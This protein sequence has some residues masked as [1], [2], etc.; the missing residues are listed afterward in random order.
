MDFPVPCKNDSALEWLV[1][2]VPA[3]RTELRSTVG[4]GQD[5]ACERMRDEL[6][7]KQQPDGVIACMKQVMREEWWGYNQ[8]ISEAEDMKWARFLLRAEVDPRQSGVKTL[9]ALA[10]VREEISRPRKCRRLSSSKSHSSGEVDLDGPADP[11][12]P[13]DARSPH[14]AH[15]FKGDA[16]SLQVLPSDRADLHGLAESEI[17][18][19][20][21]NAHPVHDFEGDAA[22][23][24][25][26]RNRLATQLKV[27]PNPPQTWGQQITQG[28]CLL[29]EHATRPAIE[30]RDV[31]I[32]AYV[33]PGKAARAMIDAGTPLRGP[34]IT[35]DEQTFKWESDR[36][37]MEQ[38]FD[39]LVNL[40][41]SVSVQD[42][43]R[44]YPS[45]SSYRDMKLR[46]VKTDFLEGARGDN[47]L[48]ILDMENPIPLTL[49]RF[50]AGND[51]NLLASVKSHFLDDGSGERRN[52]T[53]AKWKMWK[54]VENWALLAQGGAQTFLHQDSLGQATW[55]TVQQGQVGFGWIS[56]ATPEELREWRE[57]GEF[58]TDK[59][60]FVVLGKGQTVYFEAGTI[61]FVFRLNGDPTFMLGGHIM[62][63]SRVDEFLEVTLNQ[64]QYE[65]ITNE[66]VEKKAPVIVELVHQLVQDKVRE[67]RAGEIG[68]D[69]IARFYGLKKEFDT[70]MKEIK[71]S[72][73]SARSKKSAKSKKGK[74][75]T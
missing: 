73:Q 20:I 48:N 52:A 74:S 6:L 46:E 36:G 14:P 28:M 66:E 58:P 40:D 57:T 39:R 72:V 51:C 10:T 54:D 69:R 60:R 32:E 11:E 59:V 1:S 49:P 67:N 75:V 44:Q 64:L 9:L 33:L 50:L 2:R 41:R 68:E 8:V 3:F 47:P 25:A 15:D 71:G 42:P 7:A 21:H 26:I 45:D 55:L 4:T 53:I 63:W 13:A 61:H 24:D 27:Q 5:C 38:F 17:H 19:G 35:K 22:F 70:K 62:R 65:H 12:I 56:C 31:D 30:G 29:L 43:S 16:V 23:R 18:A 37:P 34:I